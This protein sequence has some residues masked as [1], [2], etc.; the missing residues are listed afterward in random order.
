MK[1]KQAEI[2]G[3]EAFRTLLDVV[4]R[5]AENGALEI[6]EDPD[7][8]PEQAD[9]YERMAELATSLECLIDEYS[10]LLNTAFELANI[11]VTVEVEDTDNNEK[12]S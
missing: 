6:A 1:T 10:D 8:D 4:N 2:E 5:T 11:K 3:I 9:T 7:L 12:E